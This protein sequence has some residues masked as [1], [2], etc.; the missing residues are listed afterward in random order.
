MEI[1]LTE[2]LTSG[3]AIHRNPT[4]WRLE[5]P[6]GAKG[7]YRLAQL[8]DY[9]HLA[10][11]AFCWRPP[12]KVGLRA[13]VSAP[14]LPGTWGFGF[15]NDPFGMSIGF[16]G[17]PRHLPALPETAWFFHASPPNSLALNDALPAR[18]F[19]AG[20]IHSVI[21]GWIALAGLPAL[22]L[23]A[24]RPLSR[25]LRR[26]ANRHIHQQ[27]VSIAADVTRWHEY[28]ASRLHEGCSFGLDGET[29]LQSPHPPSAPLGLVLWIDNQYAGWTPQGVVRFGTLDNPAA[30][31]EIADL[32]ISSG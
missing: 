3:S 18:G 1:Q 7:T 32:Q 14:D 15:W 5:I 10:G 11:R 25:Q 2:R 12:V 8:D 28:T 31:L 13:R 29:I 24:I 22:P 6:A 26:L 17:N 20:S 9:A 19:F 16:G 21:P 4:G 23:L 30:W 27:A